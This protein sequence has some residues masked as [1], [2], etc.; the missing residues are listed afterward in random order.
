M[1]L[2]LRFPPGMA[3]GLLLAYPRMKKPDHSGVVIAC[4]AACVTF[5]PLYIPAPISSILE[6]GISGTVNRLRHSGSMK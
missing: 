5:S 3:G 6:N 1:V 2:P 4:L